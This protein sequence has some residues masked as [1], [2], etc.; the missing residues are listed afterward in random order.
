VKRR[1]RA[2]DRLAHDAGDFGVETIDGCAD[3]ADQA[4]GRIR[5]T[6][7]ALQ[8]LPFSAAASSFG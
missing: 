7:E 2:C 6:V 4:T 1:E 3:N 5:S 8:T